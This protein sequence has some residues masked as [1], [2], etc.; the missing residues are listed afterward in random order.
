MFSDSGDRIARSQIEQLQG[1]LAI[2]IPI[3]SF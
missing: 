2:F 1:R 3:N